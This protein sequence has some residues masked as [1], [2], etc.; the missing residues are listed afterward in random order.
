M[1][2]ETK[3]DEKA[4]SITNTTL[5]NSSTIKTEDAEQIVETSDK[6]QKDVA[7][8]DSNVHQVFYI[9]D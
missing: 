5:N 4:C 6:H 8:I 3:I 2:G 9:R 7:N 1:I